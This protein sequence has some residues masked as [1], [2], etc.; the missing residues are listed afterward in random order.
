MPRRRLRHAS[1]DFH[2]FRMLMP[3]ASRMLCR[4]SHSADYYAMRFFT[5]H[6][7]V[8]ILL[9]RCHFAIS[10]AIVERAM[11][12]TAASMLIAADEADAAA[13]IA[14]MTYYALSANRSLTPHLSH[15]S[16]RLFFAAK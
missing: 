12:A 10:Y 3:R 6:M 14:G 8:L 2:I 9:T 16:R 1:R 7:P 13:P 15:A 11:P 4:A 5:L